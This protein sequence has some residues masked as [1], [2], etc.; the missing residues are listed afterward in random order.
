MVIRMST[1]RAVARRSELDERLGPVGQGL[2]EGLGLEILG[3]HH[4]G[5][6]TAEDDVQDAALDPV[7]PDPRAGSAS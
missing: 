7:C 3:V 1:L 4:R 6:A 2:L 5:V